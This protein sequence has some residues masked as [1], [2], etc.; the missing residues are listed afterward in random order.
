MIHSYLKS[1]GFSELKR[2]EELYAILEE[3]VNCP[4]EQRITDDEYGNEFAC[5]SK[6]YGN[7]FG[8][9]VCGNFIRD[10]EFRMEYYY[11]FFRG[12]HIST[13]E[14]IDLERQ[15]SR[16]AYAGVCDEMKLGVT[17]IFYV[18]NVIDVLHEKKY[19]KNGYLSAENA[20]LS[21]LCSGGKILLPVMKTNRQAARKEKSSENRISLMQKAREGNPAAIENLTLNDMDTYSMLCRRVEKEDI[22]SIVESTF[23]PSG[24]ESDQYIIIGE[25]MNC[26]QTENALTKEPVWI[27]TVDCNDLKFD[28]CI[29]HRDLLGEPRI[30]RRFKGQI[31][32]QGHLN[33]AY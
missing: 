8:I 21:G 27:L 4:D 10:D 20:V 25:I 24:V 30:G 16:E 17:L 23:I 1:I 3:V 14:P 18:Q 32:M 7:E 2:N 29:N 31:W 5:F 26:Y 12:S 6:Y 15:T 13:N 28:I 19:D 33:F 9:S 22:L 11:P